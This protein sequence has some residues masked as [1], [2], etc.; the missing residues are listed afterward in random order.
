MKNTFTFWE[1]TP[2]P[3][4]QEIFIKKME[5]EVKE[6]NQIIKKEKVVKGNSYNQIFKERYGY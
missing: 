2:E 4:K 5:Q 1:S 3:T 6:Q